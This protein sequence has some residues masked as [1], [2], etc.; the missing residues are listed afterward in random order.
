M[1]TEI[2]LIAK[3]DVGDEVGK[4]QLLARIMDPY[5]GDVVEN[6]LSPVDGI[7]FFAHDDPLTYASTAVYK[8]IVREP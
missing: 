4:G 5:E 2:P 3:V 8:L 1:A 7:V 6:I